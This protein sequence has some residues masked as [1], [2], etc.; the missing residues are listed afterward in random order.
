MRSIVNVVEEL[1]DMNSA[2]NEIDDEKL[3]DEMVYEINNKIEEMWREYSVSEVSKEL[4]KYEIERWDFVDYI[5]KVK[6]YMVEA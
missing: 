1:M 4:E 3:F 5:W 2:L 6:E